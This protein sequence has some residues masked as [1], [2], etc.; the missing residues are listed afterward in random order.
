MVEQF[1][2]VL[3]RSIVTCEEAGM[4]DYVFKLGD[5]LLISLRAMAGHIPDERIDAMARQLVELDEQEEAYYAEMDRCCSLLGIDAE[6]EVWH[7][8]QE[9]LLGRLEMLETEIIEAVLT[10]YQ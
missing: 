1:L 7:A 4:D 10:T 8:E 5:R 9:Q 6:S 3:A 2:A